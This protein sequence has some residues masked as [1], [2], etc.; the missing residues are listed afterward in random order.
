M[1]DLTFYLRTRDKGK[2]MANPAEEVGKVIPEMYFDLMARIVPGAGLLFA[3]FPPWYLCFVPAPSDACLVFSTF[4]TLDILWVLLVTYII[5]ITVDI[6]TSALEKMLGCRSMGKIKNYIGELPPSEQDLIKKNLAE[7][8]FFRSCAVLCFVLL[9]VYKAPIIPFDGRY[10]YGC[11]AAI[12][13]VFSMC[14]YYCRLD[15]RRREAKL[16]RRQKAKLNSRIPQKAADKAPES[17]G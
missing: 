7:A 1:N 14:H 12:L 10:Y 15:L 4:S 17:A 9:L 3:Y 8:V 6:I 16:I 11:V 13:C 2:V 5:G